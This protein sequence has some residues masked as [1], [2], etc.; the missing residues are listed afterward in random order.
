MESLIAGL[1]LRSGNDAAVR[2][3]V[4]GIKGISSIEPEGTVH[5]QD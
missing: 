2:R 4:D 1:L 3:A 5:T